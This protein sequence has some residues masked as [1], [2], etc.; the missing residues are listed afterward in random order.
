MRSAP[1]VARRG[2]TKCTGRASAGDHFGQSAARRACAARRGAP[3]IMRRADDAVQQVGGAEAQPNA[4]GDAR[5]SDCAAPTGDAVA[6]GPARR[7]R[8]A[9]IR[10]S[11]LD[12]DRARRRAQAAG[13][14]GLDAVVVVELASSRRRRSGS[15]A[16]GSSLRDLAPADD[17]LARRKRQPARRALRLAEAALDA[18]VDERVGGRQRLQVLRGARAGRRSGSRPGLSRPVRIEQVP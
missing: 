14:A 15:R 8:K 3:F 13:G 17:A 9:L 11:G 16:V 18:L 5:D 10:Q 12:A 7:P 2:G 1:A 6:S 4:C